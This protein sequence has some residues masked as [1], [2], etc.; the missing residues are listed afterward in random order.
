MEQET[1]TTEEIA[2]MMDGRAASYKFFSDALLHEFTVEQIGQLKSLAADEGASEE[3]AAAITSIRRYLAHAGSD[4]RTDLAC[5]Y[6]RIFLSAGVND[7][8]T[9]EPYESV[10]TSEEHLL[11]Q[12]ARDDALRIYRANGVDV[13]ASLRMPEDHLGLELEFMS[14]MATRTAQVLRASELDCDELARL[15]RVQT[16]FLKVHILNW[17]DQLAVKVDE[18]AKLPLYPAMMRIIIAYASDDAVLMEEL[19]GSAV[20]QAA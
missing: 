16:G 18:F 5:D 9:A 12:D 14:V 19:A 11:M 7:G 13:D 17:V 2:Q 4:P 1:L 15:A 8:I 10:F 6:A 3:V 20:S